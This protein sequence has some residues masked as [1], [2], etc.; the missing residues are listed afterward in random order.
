MQKALGVSSIAV[1]FIAARLTALLVAALLVAAC[2]RRMPAPEVTMTP[3]LSVAPVVQESGT[4][5]DRRFVHAK[6]TLINRGQNVARFSVGGCPLAIRAYSGDPRQ[7]G[8]VWS[9]SEVQ[10]A[11][12]DVL[13]RFQIAPGDSAVLEDAVTI[14]APSGSRLGAGRFAFTVSINFLE[15]EATSP[16][17]LAGPFKIRR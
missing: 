10:R 7:E 13:R 3:G 8:L 11:C 6:A 4:G 16:E 1:D 9:S 15:P 5:T 17:Y 14:N 2:V 12:P